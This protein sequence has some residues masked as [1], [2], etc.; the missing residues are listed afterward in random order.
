MALSKRKKQPGR[1]A[2]HPHQ[3]PRLG[4]STAILL[5]F[6]VSSW[7]ADGLYAK[8]LPPPTSLNSEGCSWLLNNYIFYGNKLLNESFFT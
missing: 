1:E 5:L 4:M 6:H 7:R 8:P 3:V 2:G